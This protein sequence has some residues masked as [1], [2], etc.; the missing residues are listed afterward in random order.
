MD[1]KYII[2]NGVAIPF[3]LSNQPAAKCSRALPMSALQYMTNCIFYSRDDQPLNLIETLSSEDTLLAK[4]AAKENLTRK[5]PRNNFYEIGPGNFNFAKIFANNSA[6]LENL[7]YTGCDFQ[8]AQFDYVN[9]EIKDYNGKVLFKKTPISE[10]HKEVG[11]GN[12]TLY[13]SEV[14]DDTVTEFFTMYQGKESILCSVP[15]IVYNENIPT[16][17][18]FAIDQAE[19]GNFSKAIQRMAKSNSL[20]R[21]YTP[22]EIVGLIDKIK[23]EELLQLHPG[24]LRNLDYKDK[25]ALEMPLEQ[26][27]QMYWNGMPE[28]FARYGERI[29]NFFRTQL[30]KTKEGQ[31]LHLPIA[32]INLLYRL[33]DKKDISI[34]FFDYGYE[35]SEKR[36]DPFS[37]YNGQITSPVNFG[38]LKYAAESMGYKVNL[39]KN[40]EYIQ[41]NLG[42]DTIP[43]GYVGRELNLD[44]SKMK[45]LFYQA[46]HEQVSTIQPEVNCTQENIMGYRILREE[47]EKFMKVVREAG[48]ASS[49]ESSEGSY[50]MV[51]ELS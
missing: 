6:G 20:I 36:L 16:R 29:I 46:F 21:E 17:K 12:F 39:E 22:Q 26:V 44:S 7:V 9:E 10:V 43:L 33:K 37:V 4:A 24:F 1:Q 5:N 13:L 40:R 51:A 31:V 14:L 42:L 11:E 50:H 19:Q 27:S 23:M 49:T 35:N 28:D 30:Q 15:E 18:K 32:G 38:V 48:I 8:D 47:Y 25:K 45:K 3:G 41:R 2:V 34:H